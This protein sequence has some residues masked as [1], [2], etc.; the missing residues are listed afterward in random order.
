MRL[1]RSGVAL[2]T[3]EVVLRNAIG[4]ASVA[5]LAR[6]LTPTD[7]GDVVP[8]YFLM[9]LASGIGDMGIGSAII[10]HHD[11]GREA[12]STAFWLNLGLSCAV[13]SIVL[14][15]TRTFLDDDGGNLFLY[16]VAAM[17]GVVTAASGSVHQ[18]MM[19]R[20]GSFGQLLAL[21]S[22]SSVTAA[23]AALFIAYRGGGAWALVAQVMVA[24]VVSGIG[25]WAISSWRPAMVFRKD[26][27]RRYLDFGLFLTLAGIV[28]AM[29][30]HAT[31][32]LVLRN[33]GDTRAGYYSAA[34]R[35]QGTAADFIVG[36]SSRLVFIEFSYSKS[37]SD[38]GKLFELSLLA[39]S[40]ICASVFIPVAMGAESV[41]RVLLGE[42]W[43][44]VVDVLRVL[45][46]AGFMWPLEMVCQSLIK[47]RGDLR[48]YCILEFVKRIAGFGV[49]L[50]ATAGSLIE[51]A[52]AMASLS[53][54][55]FVVNAVVATRLI[56]C[57]LAVLSPSIQTVSVF[58]SVTVAS[59]LAL[60]QAMGGGMFA[61]ILVLGIGTAVGALAA[62][63][64]LASRTDHP[65][66]TALI[67][68]LLRRR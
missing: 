34:D 54:L 25:A 68:V 5:M 23:A 38:A 40:L 30:K 49:L 46:V 2:S 20:E 18:S 29:Y 26:T 12:E 50:L 7:Y 58:G 6:L 35:L 55:F 53:V 11:L 21:S 66:S 33:L 59:I 15:G 61:E 9:T 16:A 19:M 37:A 41:V 24:G 39:V 4:L 43:E 36:I 63:A 48:G 51:A 22:M 52:I 8:I 27:L 10:R 45:C 62:F 14:L 32:M 28:N 47:A 57:G 64:M 13:A 42:R 56:G 60:K 1:S 65:A 3:I 17:V 31:S 67:R 44:A